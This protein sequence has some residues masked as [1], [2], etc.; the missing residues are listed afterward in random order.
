MS[1]RQLGAD[2]RAV[3]AGAP[4]ADALLDF[5]RLAAAPLLSEPCDHVVVQGF[6]RPAALQAINADYPTIADPGNFPLEGLSYGPGFRAFVAAMTGEAMRR[7]FGAKFGVDLGPYPTQMTVRR[8]AAPDDGY[9]HNDSVT[10]KIT[11]LVYLNRDWHQP[12]GRLRM[13]RSEHDIDDYLTEVE[14]AGGT[15]LA[16]RRNERSFHGFS[17]CEGERRSV[18]MCWV[19]PKRLERGAKKKRGPVRKLLKRWLRGTK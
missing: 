7:C 11:V 9:I 19:E 4:A 1:M 16:F 2:L 12:G 5:G 6:V 15:L 10:K 18:Q 14:P 13:L 3:G 8:F 17:R